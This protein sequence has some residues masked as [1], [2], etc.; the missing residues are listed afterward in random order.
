MNHP[1]TDPTEVHGRLV[2]LETKLDDLTDD[3]RA[4]SMK[5]DSLLTHREQERGRTQLYRSV[6]PLV[7][8]LVGALAIVIARF[9]HLIN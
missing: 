2:R 3:V 6:V 7:S 1:V 9:F 4:S 5:L 8:A